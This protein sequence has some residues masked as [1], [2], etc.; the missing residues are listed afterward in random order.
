MAKFL[1]TSAL[2]Y[3]NGVK[4][5]GNLAGSLLPADI[6]ARFRRQTGHQVLF[7]CGTDE[8]GTPAELAAHADGVPVE[9]YCGRQHQI[10]ADI[11]RRFSISFDH[12]SRTS[13][14]A[15]H[16]LTQEIFRRLDEAGFIE[17][18]LSRQAYSPSDG[19]FLPDRYLVGTCPHCGSTKARGDQCESCT[20]LLDGA[21]LVAPRSAISGAADVEFRESRHLYLRLSPFEPQL[22]QWIEN[23]TSWPGLVRS[24]ALGWF[25][26][27]LRDRCIT[28]DLS[29]GVPVP[30]AGFESKVFYVWFDAPI[31]YISAAVEWAGQIAGRDWRQ[32]WEGGE[33][34]FYVQF[35]AKDNIP[36]HT[37]SFPAT[38]V[39]S[40]LP[41]KLPDYIKGFN[42]LSFEG[43][44]FS[45]T[46][47]RGLFTD[48]ALDLLPADYWRWWLAANAPETADTDFT[49]ERFATGVNKD[50]ADV[51]GN[52]VNRC[53]AFVQTHFGGE[54]PREGQSGPIEEKLASELGEALHRL[55]SQHETI[56]FRR[57]ADETRGIWRLAN[58]YLTEAAP[59][60]TLKQDS[61][62]TAVI[63]RTAV[64]LV[65]ICA[66][67]AWAFIP[68]TAEEILRSLGEEGAVPWPQ[69]GRSALSAIEGGRLISRPPILFPKVESASA[70]REA[71]NALAQD[72]ERN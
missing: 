37:V 1:I 23:Q 65:R 70:L 42:W 24:V 29:W 34:V 67:A 66:V 55:R 71:A 7:L 47:K 10:Q 48:R 35:L 26:E 39:G 4:H 68:D 13:G 51:F 11:Y 63:V 14:P 15:H 38:V 54:V 6:H 20:R 21:D 19:R 64:N 40:G 52:L 57:A 31:G 30:R 33:D 8:H 17:E 5:L 18:R 49:W 43:G 32:W 72:R 69:D 41:L 2:P 58:V 53:L 12:F 16:R 61:V 25:N 36:F 62:R 50:L 27:G 9:E 59:W 28:R 56:A 60:L 22:R 46:D 3:I 45:T 44:K